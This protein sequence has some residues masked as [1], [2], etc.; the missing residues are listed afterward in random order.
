MDSE[1]AQRVFAVDAVAFDLDGTL[2]DTVHDLAASVNLLLAEQALPP[3]GVDVVRDLIGRGITDLLAR[4]L[5]RA[6]GTPPRDGEVAG[7]LPSY[8]R[9][10]ASIL[11]THTRLYP[12]VLRG[13]ERMRDAGFG[14]AVITNKSTRF[15]QPHLVHA[16][17]AQFFTVVIGGDDAVSKKPDAAPML[18]AAQRLGVSPA[19]MLMV[20]DSVNDVGAAR[21]AGSP[22][23][24]VPYGYNEGVPV[25]KL[26][27]DGIVD[28][29]E[30]VADLLSRKRAND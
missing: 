7:L 25:Q 30:A 18:M 4:A 15:V 5:T 21:A 16:G 9:G 23:L 14:L 24:V 2:L 22:V 11:G 27:A 8:Q 3:L 26:A 10:Y 29:L 12:G 17:I 20:G 6:R 1:P 28:S 13:L 19:R